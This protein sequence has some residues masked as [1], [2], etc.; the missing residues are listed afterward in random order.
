MRFTLL[1]L[2]G[3]LI[4]R[5]AEASPLSG[6]WQQDC[7]NRVVRTEEF[8]IGD[9]V[10]QENFFADDSC[11]TALLQFRV[12]GPFRIVGTD[13]DFRSNIYEAIAMSAD[14][15]RSFNARRVCGWSDWREG[16]VRDVSSR[17]CDFFNWGSPMQVPPAGSWRFGKWKLEN[18][19]LYFGLLTPE[20][21]GTTPARRPTTWNPSFY[22]K[23]N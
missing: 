13:I 10:Y 6:T 16:Q 5:H 1:A 23:M 18:G 8:T 12:S 3:C 7:R 2:L 22:R 15:A 17:A 21:D 11:T 20:R 19:F 4:L 14:V 9:V